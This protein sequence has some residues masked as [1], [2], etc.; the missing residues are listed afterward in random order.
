MNNLQLLL[1]QR[2]FHHTIIWKFIIAVE[3]CNCS[4]YSIWSIWCS[5][6]GWIFGLLGIACIMVL[7]L[8]SILHWI[9]GCIGYGNVY[10]THVAF[11][12]TNHPRSVLIIPCNKRNDLK[13]TLHKLNYNFLF[14]LLEKNIIGTKGKF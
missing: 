11:I 5:R 2:L 1:L 14:K 12:I 9:F 8:G 4:G 6:M 13:I 10:N 7:N 3:S